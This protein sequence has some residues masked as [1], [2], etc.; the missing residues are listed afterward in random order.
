M[1][2]LEVFEN[3]ICVNDRNIIKNELLKNVELLDRCTK[4][5]I[6]D[7]LYCRLLN[8]DFGFKEGSYVIIEFGDDEDD[9]MYEVNYG[10]WNN[11]FRVIYADNKDFTDDLWK[12]IINN[13][14]DLDD[15]YKK[16]KSKK[17][18]IM[19]TII[20]KKELNICLNYY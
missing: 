12:N 4:S 14:L 7:L 13:D 8:T 6:V 16:N 11:Y 1:S 19:K 17:V 18:F 5:N 2:S 10:V 3:N 20:M 9:I 15:F